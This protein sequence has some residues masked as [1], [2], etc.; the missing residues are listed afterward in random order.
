VTENSKLKDLVIDLKDAVNRL[1]YEILIEQNVKSVRAQNL[2][3]EI[4]CAVWSI[5]VEINNP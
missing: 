1:D 2:L 4:I 5:R 3:Q